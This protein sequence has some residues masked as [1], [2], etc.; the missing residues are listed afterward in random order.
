MSNPRSSRRRSAR[1]ATLHVNVA[2]EDPSSPRQSELLSDRVSGAGP[3]AL[4]LIRNADLAEVPGS[5]AYI[6]PSLPTFDASPFQFAV[7]HHDILSSRDR[8]TSQLVGRSFRYKD[9]EQEDDL[10]FRNNNPSNLFTI[11]AL[12]TYNADRSQFITANNSYSK[13]SLHFL[14][15]S[16]D[17]LNDYELVPA[18]S[19]H[20]SLIE[21]RRFYYLCQPNGSNDVVSFANE[22]NQ[23]DAEESFGA[24]MQGSTRA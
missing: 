2:T 9:G 22:V 1:V 17:I 7:V 10:P 12:V 8:W 18:S 15:Y 14:F 13:K 21:R 24:F 6:Q 3:P 19:F 20:P 16:S 5:F 11:H 4:S 23:S